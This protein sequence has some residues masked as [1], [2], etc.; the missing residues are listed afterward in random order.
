M[1]IVQ[2]QL[3]GSRLNKITNVVLIKNNALLTTFLNDQ[4]EITCR[5][6][7]NFKFCSQ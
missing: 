7:E 1:R 6:K 5:L 4:R 3:F 2:I